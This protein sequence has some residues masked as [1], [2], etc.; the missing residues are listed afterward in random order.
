MFHCVEYDTEMDT[1]GFFIHFE[2]CS[3]KEQPDPK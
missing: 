3:F 1:A 2:D